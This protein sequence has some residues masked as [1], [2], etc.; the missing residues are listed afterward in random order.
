MVA[1]L[2]KKEQDYLRKADRL[3]EDID[4]RKEVLR[5]NGTSKDK[6]KQ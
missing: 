1:V 3:Q 6:K 5:D 4:R 2:R